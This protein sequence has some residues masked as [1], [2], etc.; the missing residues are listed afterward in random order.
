MGGYVQ[1]IPVEPDEALLEAA[2]NP[3]PSFLSRLLG[4]PKRPTEHARLDSAAPAVGGETAPVE[5]PDYDGLVTLP[6]GK[7]FKKALMADFLSWVKND[8][9]V[10]W[11]STQGFCNAYLLSIEH[12]VDLRGQRDKA[13]E[14]YYYF[15]ELSFSGCGGMAELSS[16]LAAHWAEI[17][18]QK[19]REVIEREYLRPHQLALIQNPKLDIELEDRFIPAGEYGYACYHSDKELA[20]WY[21][22]EEK[23]PHFG[24]DECWKQGLYV[25]YDDDADTD[26]AM[27]DVERFLEESY[28]ELM[29]D[30]LC[31]CQLCMPDFD[32]S[33]LDQ[34]KI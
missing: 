30:G 25:D 29:S 31:R 6:V 10:P 14:P 12:D 23:P 19:R 1:L 17:W 15:V 33:E 20:K 13:N 4:K 24:V 16:A 9:S 7:K 26:S 2:R 28:T 11:L 22:P 3:K 32:A 21:K 27:L 8:I 5:Q 34:F 18:Y